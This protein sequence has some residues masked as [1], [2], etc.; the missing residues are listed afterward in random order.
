MKIISFFLLTMLLVV[1]PFVVRAHGS[2]VSYTEEVNGYSVDIDYSTERPEVGESVIFD[3]KLDKNGAV[4]RNFSDVWV[5]ITDGEK[6]PF[7][8]GIY[9]SQFGGARMTY[10]FPTSGNY[11]IH[12]RYENADGTLAEVSFPLA[13]VESEGTPNNSFNSTWILYALAGAVLGFGVASLV[14]KRA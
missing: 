11:E 8:A 10:V 1:T 6:T 12:A 13:V 2:G 9:N 7:A 14:K 5:R 3:F 4:A